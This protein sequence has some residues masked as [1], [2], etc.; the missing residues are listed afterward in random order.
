[1]DTFVTIFIIILAIPFIAPYPIWFFAIRPF[2]VKHN[3]PRITAVNWL[4][5]MW[6][7]DREKDWE[8][9]LGN[10]IVLLDMGLYTKCLLL[11]FWR[12]RVTGIGCPKGYT[13]TG[14]DVHLLFQRI[15]PFGIFIPRLSRSILW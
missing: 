7:R 13:Q 15:E 6:A 1:M 14:K 9:I 3:R 4:L 2:I 10:A 12:D 5:S 11:I 8:T